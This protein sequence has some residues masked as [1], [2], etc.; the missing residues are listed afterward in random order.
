MNGHAICG[1][2]RMPLSLFG[3]L[4]VLPKSQLHDMLNHFKF[5]ISWDFLILLISMCSKAPPLK[6]INPL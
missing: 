3:M 1:I 2:M 6:V 4:V 5:Y